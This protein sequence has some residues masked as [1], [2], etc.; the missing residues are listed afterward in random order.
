MAMF[1]DIN[2][3]PGAEHHAAI[4]DGNGEVDGGEGGADVGRH[5]VIAFGGM[6]EH[7]VAVGDE[8]GEEGFEVAADVGIGVFLDEQRGGGVAEM[9]GEETV[10]KAFFGKPVGDVISDFVEAAAAG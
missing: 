9:E 7:A 3:L 4:A 6:D 1:P 8:A 10:L 5:I 2:A